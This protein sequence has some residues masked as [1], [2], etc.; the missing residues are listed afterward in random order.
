MP[1]KRQT[2]VRERPPDPTSLAASWRLFIA[3]P[4]PP[5]VTGMVREIVGRLSTDESLPVR[6][7]EADQAHLTLQFIGEVPGEQA[8]L[9]RMAIA[10][11][12]AAHQVF[13]L[14]TA[15]LGVFPS[16][17][18]P[19]VLWVGLHGP[20]HRL[21]SIRNDLTAALAG[22]EVPHDVTPYHPHITIGRFRSVANFKTR[23]LPD[24]IRT[25]FAE[26]MVEGLGTM[27]QPVDIP[28]DEVLLLR[29]LIDHRGSTYEV[30]G[31]YPLA[32]RHPERGAGAPEVGSGPD[33]G[34]PK[35]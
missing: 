14:R 25:R 13:R 15:D 9:I 3:I 24:R 6:W 30:V 27:R 31:R 17:R 5:A 7:V 21:E 18:R 16:I 2:F 8:E 23:D 33:A 19:R 26:L 22:I 12:F 34:M 35:R 32:P 1:K 20:T 10:P 4:L 29:S 28:I 11:V